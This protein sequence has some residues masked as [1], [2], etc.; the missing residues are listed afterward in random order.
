MLSARFAD[1]N[2][3]F[4]L[5][6]IHK[7]YLPSM[8]STTPIIAPVDKLCWMQFS[9]LLAILFTSL[10]YWKKVSNLTCQ[11][12]FGVHLP[13]NPTQ[14]LMSPTYGMSNFKR[15][16]NIQPRYRMQINWWNVSNPVE[17]KTARKKIRATKKNLEL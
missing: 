3:I 12:K 9:R 1:S 5:L 11:R 16:S 8:V 6:V 4:L 13:C 7:L 15:F 14:L 10:N 2:Q 17:L